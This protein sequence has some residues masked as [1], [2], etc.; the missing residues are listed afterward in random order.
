M[1]CDRDLGRN[2]TRKKYQNTCNCFLGD[3][4]CCPEY[5]RCR[6]RLSGYFL[7]YLWMVLRVAAFGQQVQLFLPGSS[8]C[9]ACRAKGALQA[10]QGSS[11]AC[12]ALKELRVLKNKPKNPTNNHNNYNPTPSQPTDQNQQAQ[13]LC[14]AVACLGSALLLGYPSTS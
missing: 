9:C 3:P 1:V 6:L 14:P 7:E 10:L 13:D 5:R 2:S 8:V 12:A 11:A 4:E